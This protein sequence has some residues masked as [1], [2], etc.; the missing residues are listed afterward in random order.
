MEEMAHGLI[1]IAGIFA[2]PD[3]LLAAYGLVWWQGTKI[4]TD[5]NRIIEQAGIGRCDN[6]CEMGM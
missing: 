2:G 3:T 1:F 6:G 4:P 5:R